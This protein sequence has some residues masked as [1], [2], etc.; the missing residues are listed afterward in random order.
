VGQKVNP[1]G[2]RLGVY[3]DWDASWFA[4]RSY[5]D[6]VLEDIKIRDFL[7]SALSRAEVSRIRIEKAG[8][9]IKVIINSARPGQVIGKKGQ[10]IESLRKDLA[11][12]LK[13]DNV[14]VSV[15]EVKQPEL[16]ATIVAKSIAEQIE[17]RVNYKKAMKK[18]AS[19]TLKSGAKGIKI[20]VAGR[21]GGAEIARS[22]WLRMGSIPLHTLRVDIDYG[23]AQAK[24]KY[25]IIGV[26]VWISRGEFPLKKNSIKS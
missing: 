17:R 5:G 21:L 1:I 2:F 24:T 19:T 3:L 10:G 9:S 23:F 7:D 16:D 25:G 20:C 22:E 13:K 8:E 12:I 14:E 18:A 15:Q 11:R 6:Q 4:R 26:K